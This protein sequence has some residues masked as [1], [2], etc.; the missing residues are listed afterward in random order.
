MLGVCLQG[1]GEQPSLGCSSPALGTATV[2]VHQQKRLG[3]M[4]STFSHRSA[5]PFLIFLAA[6]ETESGEI[7][8]WVCIS[9]CNFSVLNN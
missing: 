8:F 9:F 5:G 4:P 3:E 2:G 7:P 1:T 6:G